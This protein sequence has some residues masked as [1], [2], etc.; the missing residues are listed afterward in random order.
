[1][2]SGL[3]SIELDFANMVTGHVIWPS[4][5]RQMIT[6]D[7]ECDMGCWFVTVIGVS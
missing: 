6:L 3:M 4:H 2:V 1:M 5:Y 7:V